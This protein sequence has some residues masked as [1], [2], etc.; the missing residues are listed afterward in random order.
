LYYFNFHHGDESNRKGMDYFMETPKKLELH[1]K[2][3][4]ADDQIKDY[5][6]EPTKNMKLYSTFESK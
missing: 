2:F 5:L 4:K 1:R 6:I 3:P